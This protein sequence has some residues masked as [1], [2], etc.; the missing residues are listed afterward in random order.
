MPWEGSIPTSTSFPE[1][2]PGCGEGKHAPSE[3]DMLVASVGGVGE[4]FEIRGRV[5]N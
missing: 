1:I 4:E 3:E 2:S 5:E